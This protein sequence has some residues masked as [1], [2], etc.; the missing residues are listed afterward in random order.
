VNGSNQR[1]DHRI[2]G[3]GVIAGQIDRLSDFKLDLGTPGV[4]AIA[5]TNSMRTFAGSI[6]IFMACG[7]VGP[8]L[9]WATWPPTPAPRG[10]GFSFDDFIYDL[11]LFLWPTQPL[12]AMEVTIGSF[13][14][15]TLSI[16]ANALLFGIVAALAAII[17]RQPGKLLG[18]YVA[19]C[20]VV[21]LLALWSAGF[22]VAFL[23]VGALAVAFLLYAVPFLAVLGLARKG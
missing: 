22:S 21:F 2:P 13:A 17:A 15:I 10:S 7:L 4:H 12:A 8:L 11:V 6:L 20:I 23:N 3:V 16:G 18:L 1:F 14:A 9:R 5:E 19:T